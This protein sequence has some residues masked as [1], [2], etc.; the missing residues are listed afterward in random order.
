MKPKLT[1]EMVAQK[2]GVSITTVSH[3]INKTRHVNQETKDAVLK[4]MKELNYHSFKMAKSD[5]AN[6]ICIGVILADVREDYYNDMIKALE[7]VADDY[8]VSIIFCDSEADFEKEEKN[9]GILLGRQVNGLLLA[10][11]DADRIPKSLKNIPIPV[12]LID[13]QYESHSFLSVG[14]NNFQ[15]SYLGTR[16]IFEKGCKNIGFIGYSD[17]VD[18][19]RKRIQGYRAAVNEFDPAAIPK[20]LYLKY[21]GGDSFPLIKQ[22]IIE[23]GF[24][25]LVCATSALCNEVIEV[26]DTLD[27]GIQKRMKII[28]YDDNRW[29]DYLKYPV[30]VISQPVAEIGNAAVENLLQMIEQPNYTR[31]IKRELLFDIT[32]IDRIADPGP[33]Q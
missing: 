29:L 28:S 15:S 19:I 8:G 23:G 11:A 12:V 18:T 14:I 10:P 24:D 1:M 4:V 9:I 20:V 21:N 13:R 22:F 27:S 30:S 16:C 17:P 7:S 26:L 32:I 33:T 5:T 2:A 31:D 25:G 3:V 6:G